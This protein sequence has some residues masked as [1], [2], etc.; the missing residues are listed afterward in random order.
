MPDIVNL[1]VRLPRELHARLRDRADA[2]RRSLN[3]EIVW[4]LD[5]GARAAHGSKR[6]DPS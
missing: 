5:R 1:N 6:A 2:E 4:M 3:A